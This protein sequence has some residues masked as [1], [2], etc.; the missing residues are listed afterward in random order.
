MNIGE[1]VDYIYRMV[2]KLQAH[3]TAMQGKI[4]ENAND[5]L[6]KVDKSL[7][8]KMFEKFQAVIGEMAGRVDELKDCI[9]ETATRD[10][11]NAMIE[12][13]FNS[14]TQGGQTAI[15]RVRCIACGRE[16]PQVTG[17][18]SEEDATRML[19]QPTNS[20]AGKGGTTNL[21]LLYAKKDGM[22]SA[23][24]ESPRSIRPFKPQT[25]RPKTPR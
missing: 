23:I 10:E 14:M 17:A 12:D 25:A 7:V 3:L 20:Y 16:I 19:G 24:I 13:I 8:E 1:V 4:V 5:I 22:D 11:I 2:P 18:T 21:G 15:G 6:G 9:E